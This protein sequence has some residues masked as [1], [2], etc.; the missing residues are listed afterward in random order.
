MG[1]KGHDP[2]IQSFHQEL[3]LP[4]TTGTTGTSQ[5]SHMA[6][7]SLGNRAPV[8][9]FTGLPCPSLADFDDPG[10]KNSHATDKFSSY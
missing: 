5:L 8:E 3:G 7:P 2:R 6:L 9:L 10:L 4:G 1:T